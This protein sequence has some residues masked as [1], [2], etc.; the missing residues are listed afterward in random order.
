MLVSEVSFML[1]H[2][3]VY[4]SPISFEKFYFQL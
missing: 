2:V 1:L 3:K 4:T